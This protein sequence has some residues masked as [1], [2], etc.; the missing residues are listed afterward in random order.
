MSNPGPQKRWQQLP[1]DDDDAAAAEALGREL[2]LHPLVA[3]LLIRRGRLTAAQAQAFLAPRLT[4]LHDPALLPGATRAA[5]RIELAIK[6]R[7]PIVIYGDYDVDGITAS[8]I[9]WHML[10]LAGA[11]VSTYVPHRI[12]EGYGLNSEA[13]AALCE[14]RETLGER[15]L[16]ISVD[17]GITAVEP[18]AV[19]KAAGVD[20]IITD[21]HHFEADA[22]PDAYALVHPDLP[23]S[24]YPFRG[25]CGAGVAFKL[26]WHF[27]R[28]HCGGTQKL[29]QAYRDVL[30]DLVSLAALGTV[31]DVVPLLEENRVMTAIGLGQVKRTKFIGLNALI[32]A[33]DLRDEKI[34]AYHVGFVLGPRINACGRMGHARQAVHLLTRAQPNEAVQIAEFLTQENDRRRVTER[35][36]FV[37]AKEMV[38]AQGYHHDSRRVIVVGKEGWHQGVIGI[39]ASRLVDAYNRPAIV[40]TFGEVGAPGGA[41]VTEAAEAHGSARSVDGVSIHEALQACAVHLSSFGGHAMAAGMRLPVSRVDALRESLIEFINQRLTIDDLT[42]VVTIESECELGDLTADTMTQLAKLEPSGRNNEKPIFCVRGAVVDRQASRMGGGGRHLNVLLRKGRTS[43]RAV[44]WHM[45]D[46]AE[47]LAAG[48]TVDAV[49]EAKVSEWNGQRRVELMLEDIVVRRG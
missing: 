11:N 42:P 49:F 25:L 4:D 8:A 5:E 40:L 38:E 37:E 41:G 20:L 22:L 44:G 43:L 34:D 36:I 30:L 21:H 32:D 12:E 19:A 23:G 27:A 1:W 31:A 28:L 13:I 3:R 26:A 33:S 10:H 18:A 15:P 48:V 14:G 35:T 17:C 39:V 45:G 7:Q 9:L 2:R 29:P 16:I 47:K 46:L 24:E 6:S